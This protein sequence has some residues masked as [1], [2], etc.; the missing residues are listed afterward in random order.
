MTK[1]LHRETH[2]PNDGTGGSRLPV[3]P[4]L[5][6]SRSDSSVT[7]QARGERPEIGFGHERVAPR[8]RVAPGH[9]ASSRSRPKTDGPNAAPTRPDPIAMNRAASSNPRT[10]A[11]NAARMMP[12]R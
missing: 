4:Q 3:S 12:I 2:F 8:N 1:L 9:T 6:R 7:A 5:G 11:T 10:K